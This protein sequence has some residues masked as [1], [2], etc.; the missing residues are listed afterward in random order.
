MKAS[1]QIGAS[2][3]EAVQLSLRNMRSDSLEMGGFS[4]VAAALADKQWQVTKVNNSSISA[5]SM[6]KENENIQIQ[7]KEETILK[8]WRLTSMAKPIKSLRP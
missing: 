8:S 1:F 6:R 3:G 5:T 2:S 4:Y 7:A